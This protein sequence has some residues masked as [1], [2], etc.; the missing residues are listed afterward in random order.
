MI[1]IEHHKYTNQENKQKFLV[2][3][4]M[5]TLK[6]INDVPKVDLKKKFK[7]NI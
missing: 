4:R 3:N 6:P 1:N 2:Q 7:E 5:N